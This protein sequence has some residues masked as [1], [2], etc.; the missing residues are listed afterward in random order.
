MAKFI[1]CTQMIGKT[2]LIELANIARL[3]SLEDL[4]G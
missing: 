1:V 3:Y 4:V 2:P